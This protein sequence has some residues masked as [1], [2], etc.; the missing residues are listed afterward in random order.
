M[1]D[2]NICIGCGACIGVC[3]TK[4][5]S[6]DGEG[7]AQIDENICIKCGTCEAICPVQAIKINY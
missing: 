2:K 6:F 1:I 5:I 4:A 7:K 3:P